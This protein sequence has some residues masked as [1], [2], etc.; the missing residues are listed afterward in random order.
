M[1]CKDFIAEGCFEPDGLL[2][3]HSTSTVACLF[4]Q[5]CTFTAT[6]REAVWHAAVFTLTASAVVLPPSPIGPIPSL[7]TASQS[8]CSNASILSIGWSR[9]SLASAGAESNVPPI[10]TPSTTGG[11]GRPSAISIVPTTT[12]SI[13]PT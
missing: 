11:Q 12:S 5:H 8:F 4:G 3:H 9:A 2:A 13:F 10:P 6:G 7:F 1:D